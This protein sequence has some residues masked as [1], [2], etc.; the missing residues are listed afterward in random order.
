MRCPNA[1]LKA[2]TG[3]AALSVRQITGRDLL[4]RKRFHVI[5]NSVDISRAALG[6]TKGEE[7]RRR[8]NIPPDRLVVT[9]VS[10]LIP[11]KGVDDLL[12]AAPRRGGC[13]KPLAHFLAGR[14]ALH[15]P[16]LE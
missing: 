2:V 5:Y 1:H 8:H 3:G 9:Q 6:L 4:P 13:R 14:R 16:Y 7:F 12:T 15:R 11:E 10:W